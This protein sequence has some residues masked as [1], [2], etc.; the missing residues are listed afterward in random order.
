MDSSKDIIDLTSDREIIVL[1][2]EPE[3]TTAGPSK[4]PITR[5]SPLQ[6]HLNTQSSSTV[7]DAASRSAT[8][9]RSNSLEVGSSSQGQDD[10]RRKARRKKRKSSVVFEKEGGEDGEIEEVSVTEKEQPVDSLGV[11]KDA[12]TYPERQSSK[13]KEKERDSRRVLS[14]RGS[15]ERSRAASADEREDSTPKPK[16]P[17]D[18][19]KREKKRKRRDKVR[20]RDQDDQRARSETPEKQTEELPLFYIDEEP[21]EIPALSK[22]TTDPP[23]NKPAPKPDE[24]AQSNTPGLLLPAHVTVFEGNGEAPIEILPPPPLDSED[25]DYIEYLDYDDNRR[26]GLVRYFDD[27]AELAATKAAKATRIV[28]KNCGAEGEHKTYECPVVIEC[29]TLWRMYEYVEETER[30]TLIDL[31]EQ[32]RDLALGEGGEGYIAPEDWCYNCGGCGHLGDDC[33]EHVAHTPHDRPRGPSA[34]SEYNTMTGPFYDSAHPT[35]RAP[36]RAAAYASRAKNAWGDGYGAA[37]PLDVGKQGRKKERARLEKRAQELQ[38]DDED[39][40]FANRPPNR[41]GR[42]GG[43]SGKKSLLDRLESTSS[44]KIGFGN[45]GKDRGGRRFDSGSS[46]GRDSR[47]Q[48]RRKNGGGRSDDHDY[49]DLPAPMRETDTLQIRGAS[50]RHEDRRG[51]N[52]REDGEYEDDYHRKD[53]SRSR[54]REKDRNKRSPERWR[55]RGKERDRDRSPRR[56]PR[57]RGGYSR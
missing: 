2:S 20:Q 36:S 1:D 8:H 32:K 49:D 41:S 23:P 15:P 48:K 29:P 52:G 42:D 17:K 30:Q 35:Q 57:Y 19:R 55:D 11:R 43:S 34:F 26:A 22:P 5:S 3:D 21:A 24:T 53:S 28:C 7:V 40:W 33:K 39:D 6:S 9:T 10:K 16:N 45:L 14:R 4:I 46:K 18:A 12:E 51:W 47:D 50:R 56:E 27:P 37:L 44:Q 54:N 38:G 13:G 25:D 31:R